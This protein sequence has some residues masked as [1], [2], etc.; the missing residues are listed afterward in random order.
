MAYRKTIHPRKMVAIYESTYDEIKHLKKEDE[1]WDEFMA[2][3]C[4]VKKR[5]RR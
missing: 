2:R 1:T 4:G 3:I 5:K